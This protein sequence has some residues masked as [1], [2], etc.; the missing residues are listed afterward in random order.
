MH[1]KHIWCILKP[2]FKQILIYILN[3]C[4]GRKQNKLDWNLTEQV[5]F[6]QNKAK[7]KNKSYIYEFVR[8]DTIL[9]S[10]RRTVMQSLNLLWRWGKFR[11][12]SEYVERRRL[13]QETGESEAVAHAAAPWGKRDWWLNGESETEHEASKLT[14]P[15]RN[16]V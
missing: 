4:E 13:T 11:S 6:G 15:A 2:N 3:L 5:T 8:D 16:F 10:I 9:N 7:S 1:I 14:I 12:P